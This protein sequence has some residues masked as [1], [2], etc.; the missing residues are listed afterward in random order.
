MDED[1]EESVCRRLSIAHTRRYGMQDIYETVPFFSGILKKRD[2][3]DL[4]KALN[5][6]EF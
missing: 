5:Q 1:F 2:R 3:E 4:K 6:E